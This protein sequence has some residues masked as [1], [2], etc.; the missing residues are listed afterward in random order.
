MRGEQEMLELIVSTAQND[1]RIR[2]VML[3]GSRLNIPM[4]MM[5]E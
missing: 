5:K 1:D 2:A 4:A 3:N